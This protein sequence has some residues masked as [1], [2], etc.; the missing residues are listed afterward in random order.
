MP[1]MTLSQRRVR[2]ELN[3]FTPPWSSAQTLLIQHGMGRNADFWRAWPPM[4]GTEVSIV[5]RDLP[6]HG[7]SQAPPS[8]YRWSLDTLVEELV[9]FLDALGLERVHFLGESTAGMLGIAFAARHPQ[10]LHSLILCAAPTTIGKAAQD[11]FA[12][13]HSSWQS[14]IRTLGSGGWA[15][16]LAERGG[17]M[18]EMIQEQREWVFQQ[19][20]RIPIEVL[21][22]YSEMVSNTDVSS[23]LSSIRTPTLILAPTASAA[24]PLPQQRALA[25]QIAGSELV[26]IDGSG[27]EIY[28]DRAAA[29]CKAVSG[30]LLRVARPGP[31]EPDLVA[32][33][34]LE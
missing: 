15:R 30:F 10:R 34:P 6:G 27:H 1:H 24:T 26:E 16:A 21:V 7:D 5:R 14:A 13:G 20:E 23:L 12:C 2:Y 18:G 17:T 19:F 28:V 3:D 9:A 25:A 32:C 22:G 31:C 11:F 4:L 8:G 33:D 29:C